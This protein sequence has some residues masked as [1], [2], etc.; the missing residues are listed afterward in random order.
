MSLD[1]NLFKRILALR[2]EIYFPILMNQLEFIRLNI[3]IA[4]E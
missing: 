3:Q 2:R 1:F 4:R